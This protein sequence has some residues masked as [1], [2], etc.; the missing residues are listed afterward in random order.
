MQGYDPKKHISDQLFDAEQLL[1][2]DTYESIY[3]PQIEKRQGR[4]IDLL[5]KKRPNLVNKKQAIEGDTFS[6]DFS[7]DDIN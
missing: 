7:S 1:P 6:A 5:K 2:K 3:K 4:Y